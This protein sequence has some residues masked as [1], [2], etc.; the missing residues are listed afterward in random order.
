MKSRFNYIKMGLVIGA[1]MFAACGLVWGL[2]V[3]S[4]R[5]GLRLFADP[6]IAPRVVVPRTPIVRTTPTATPTLAPAK[7]DWKMVATGR[8][9]QTPTMAAITN[10][11]TRKPTQKPAT[12][13]LPAPA[14]TPASKPPVTPAPTVTP[15]VTPTLMPEPTQDLEVLR[16][17]ND[18]RISGVKSE[19]L[20]MRVFYQGRIDQYDAAVASWTAQSGWPPSPM[21]DA[22]LREEYGVDEAEEAL[23]TID[24][25][26]GY[27]DFLADKNK[28]AQSYDELVDISSEIT[29][30]EV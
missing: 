23:E 14:V 8:V 1:I 30:L 9:E 3:L 27:M 26:L 16:A 2:V 17:Q 22:S 28:N 11:P 19:L 7:I 20:E 18:G 4:G 24:F 25:Y 6:T 21:Y 29:R 5:E 10:A 12:G 15:T 13:V